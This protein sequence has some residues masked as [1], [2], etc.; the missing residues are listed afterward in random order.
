MPYTF[1]EEATFSSP[2]YL[3]TLL[4]SPA[5]ICKDANVLNVPK[6]V[7]YI[8]I[9]YGPSHQSPPKQ[10]PLRART[11]TVQSPNSDSLQQSQQQTTSGFDYQKY[12]RSTRRNRINDQKQRITLIAAV[13]DE[14]V[15]MR[16]TTICRVPRPNTIYNATSSS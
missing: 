9:H 14:A 4:E 15:F 3:Q 2:T 6:P 10:Q 16:G 7:K 12:L 13:P 5:K 11:M 8:K 1:D